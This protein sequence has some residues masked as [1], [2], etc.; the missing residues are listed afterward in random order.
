MS[1]GDSLQR[2]DSGLA[3]CCVCPAQHSHLP[4]DLFVFPFAGMERGTRQAIYPDSGFFV[5]WEYSLHGSSTMCKVLGLVLRT[6]SQ[7]LDVVFCTV[8][9]VVSALGRQDDWKIGAI[10]G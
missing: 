7:K 1:S 10:L 4:C 2:V 5:G 6:T 9:P 8:I 3:A